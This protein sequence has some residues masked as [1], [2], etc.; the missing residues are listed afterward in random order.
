MAHRNICIVQDDKSIIPGINDPE[1]LPGHFEC[2]LTIIS[3]YFTEGQVLVSIFPEQNVIG[4]LFQRL[5]WAVTIPFNGLGYVG[6]NSGPDRSH[7]QCQGSS[8]F[9]I[10][11]FPV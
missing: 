11:S 3:F 10:A 7:G 2:V 9:P 4:Y 1:D 8:S 5:E 6:L